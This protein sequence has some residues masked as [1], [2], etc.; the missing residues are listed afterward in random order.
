MLIG[1]KF[2][3]IYSY[4]FLNNRL[5]KNVYISHRKAIR[6]YYVFKI[7]IKLKFI[8]GLHRQARH[9]PFGEAVARSHLDDAPLKPGA[10]GNCLVF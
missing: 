6:Y 10:T 1:S 7:I 8:S 9:L 3:V 5:I 2:N 4:S